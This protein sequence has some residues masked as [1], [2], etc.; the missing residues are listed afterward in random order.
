[1]YVLYIRY[2]DV[3]SKSL[4]FTE[5]SFDA[6]DEIFDHVYEQQFGDLTC[7]FQNHKRDTKNPCLNVQSLKPITKEMLDQ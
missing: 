3:Y 7:F 1:M 6:L 5:D 4:L 2:E